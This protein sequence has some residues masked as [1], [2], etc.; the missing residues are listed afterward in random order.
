MDVK[1]AIK[2]AK[3]Y[4]SEVF[5]EEQVT[6]L[7]LDETEYDPAAGRWYIAV[8]FSRPW[9]KQTLSFCNSVV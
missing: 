2:P 1:D 7:G 8:G 4:V 9:N 3:D 5:A 6:N